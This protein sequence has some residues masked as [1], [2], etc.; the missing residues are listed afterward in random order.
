MV[1]RNR[2]REQRYNALEN[3]Q[4]FMSEELYQTLRTIDSEDVD[5]QNE[6]ITKLTLINLISQ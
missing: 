2:V 1:L 4:D 5:V 3:L 6:R